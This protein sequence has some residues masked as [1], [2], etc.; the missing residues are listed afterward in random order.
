MWRGFAWLDTGTPDSLLAAADFVATL[1]RRN[2]RR[3][4]CPGEVR[5]NQGYITRD[6]LERLGLAL[7]NSAYARYVWGLVKAS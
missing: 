1:E 2:G 6:E 4:A 3:I 7:G 5:F